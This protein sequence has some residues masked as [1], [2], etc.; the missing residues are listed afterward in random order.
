MN[1]MTELAISFY[2][3]EPCR[4]CGILMTREAL[5]DA[6]FAGY[7]KCNKSRTAHK[8]CWTQDLPKDIWAYSE[9]AE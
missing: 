6:V 1:S 7:S 5:N 2:V 8:H 9:D 3:G 4:I